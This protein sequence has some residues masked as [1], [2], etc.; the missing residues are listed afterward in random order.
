MD[1]ATEAGTVLVMAT[2]MDRATETPTALAMAAVMDRAI[3][4]AMGDTAV[5]SACRAFS[6]G[7]LVV[8]A[9]NV[10]DWELGWLP[11]PPERSLRWVFLWG[12]AQGWTPTDL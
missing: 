6:R 9:T 10:R 7:F 12:A 4:A 1:Q 3:A 11:Y 2:V 8:I 5:T